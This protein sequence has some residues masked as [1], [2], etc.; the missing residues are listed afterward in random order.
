MNDP[1]TTPS[2]R[3][4]WI[5][6]PT[7]KLGLILALILLLQV[8]LFAVGNLIGEREARQDEVLAGIRR[9]WGP[10]QAI[11]GPTLAVPY[12]WVEPATQAVPA[13]R[14]RGWVLV[15][16]RTLAVT[17]SLAP[18]TRQRGLFHAIV[19]TAAVRLAGTVGV[20]RIDIKDAPGAELLWSQAVLVVGATDLRGQPGDGTMTVDG[21]SVPLAVQS[22]GGGCGGLATSPAGLG[23]PAAPG[24]TITFQASLALRGTQSFAVVPWGQQ[25]DMRVSAPWPTPSFNGVALPLSYDIDDTGF[26]AAWQVSGDAV[27]GGFA[28][29]AGSTTNAGPMSN[30]GPLPG[31]G[32]TETDSA[33]GVDLLE[34]VPTYLMV[35]RTAKYGTLFLVLSFLTYFLIEQGTG[36]RIHLAQYGLLGLSIALFALLVVALAEPLGFSAG[37]AISTAAVMSQASL[38]TLSV[39]QRPR[40]A[41]LFAAVM[42]LLFAL[43]YVV[44]RL[45]SYALLA[46]TAAL[47]VILSV[48]MAATRRLDWTGGREEPVGTGRAR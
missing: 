46:G 23:G 11:T 28:T 45:E 37:Y 16:P 8:P 22:T 3:R 2:P 1:L 18:E 24:T 5:A 9:S 21:Q 17:A 30:P 39:T 36:L 32:G 33:A 42:G 19:Y 47:F 7:A 31:C 13:Q 27:S 26:R 34:A 44:L 20:P 25:I 35:T 29:S 15:P 43:L 14:R 10:A 6:S 4:S 48:V 38:Y 41:L 40:L 12:A